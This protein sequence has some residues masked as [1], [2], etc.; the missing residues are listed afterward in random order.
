VGEPPVLA[1]EA[2]QVFIDDVNG[3]DEGEGTE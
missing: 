2:F 1:R 3:G